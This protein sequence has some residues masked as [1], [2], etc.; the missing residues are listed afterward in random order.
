[1]TRMAC[2][3]AGLRSAPGSLPACCGSKD[4]RSHMDTQSSSASQVFLIT[5]A[6][7]GSCAI[8]AEYLGRMLQWWRPDT[9][10]LVQEAQIPKQ[11]MSDPPLI[12]PGPELRAR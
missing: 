12:L 3:G 1:M 4:G 9:R 8:T 11:E 2:P 10:W 7:P 6:N 5:R